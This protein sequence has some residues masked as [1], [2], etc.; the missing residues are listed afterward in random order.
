[1]FILG[2]ALISQDSLFTFAYYQTHGLNVLTGAVG[3]WLFLRVVDMIYCL[4]E[5]RAA[6]RHLDA[7]EKKWGKF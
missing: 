5:R 2:V 4:P 6:K 3:L 7:I 1:M